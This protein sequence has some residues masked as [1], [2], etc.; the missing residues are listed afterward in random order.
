MFPV[1]RWLFAVIGV[2]LGVFGAIRAARYLRF[3]GARLVMLDMPGVIGGSFLARLDLP[4]PLPR[5]TTVTIRLVNEKKRAER[6][7][8]SKNSHVTRTPVYED[9][10]THEMDEVS[11]RGGKYSLSVAHEI[12]E[13]AKDP[14]IIEQARKYGD[15]VRVTYDWFLTAKASLPGADLDLKFELPVYRTDG[16]IPN[17]FFSR[18]TRRGRAE[19]RLDADGNL[20]CD[21]VPLDRSSEGETK[22]ERSEQVD[23]QLSSE[24]ALSDEVSS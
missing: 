13:H 2:G 20:T 5:G 8:G 12:P 10:T 18:I 7:S 21:I 19:H 1:G 6:S 4:K 14:R 24:S 17:G 3:S 9:V 22:N 16:S 15:T 23:G 11:F